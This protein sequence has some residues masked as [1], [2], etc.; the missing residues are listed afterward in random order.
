MKKIMINTNSQIKLKNTMLKS[1]L[2]DD[3]DVYTH[4]CIH[5]NTCIHAW[6]F[7]ILI[8]VIFLE[9]VFFIDGFQI[10]FPIKQI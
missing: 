1:K 7:D 10:C 4:T 9:R 3:S 8:L 6:D 5:T 2:C